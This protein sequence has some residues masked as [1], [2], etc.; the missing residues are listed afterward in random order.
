MKIF[1][2][3]VISRKTKFC[4]I[5]LII[6][7]LFFPQLFSIIAGTNCIIHQQCNECSLGSP[8][9]C[10]NENSYVSC[11]IA[12]QKVVRCNS[13]Q[14]CK[15]GGIS[16]IPIRSEICVDVASFPSNAALEFDCQNRCV[17]LCTN[18]QIYTCT[19]T[20]TYKNCGSGSIESTCPAGNICTINAFCEPQT[21]NIAPLC[22]NTT[23]APNSLCPAGI[24]G[25][26]HLD[27]K[28]P[29]CSK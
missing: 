13:G 14:I 18:D 25:K 26:F 8:W 1:L 10:I 9:K 3:A 7:F 2:I 29:Y 19:G 6:F 4:F 16:D 11:L 23:P 22:G 15:Y 12:N 20:N 21:A 17:G 24:R 27:P 5:F 28:D